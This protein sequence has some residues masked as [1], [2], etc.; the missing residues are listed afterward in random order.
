MLVKTFLIFTALLIQIILVIILVPQNTDLVRYWINVFSL[1]ESKKLFG[2]ISAS[3]I[4]FIIPS[5][6]WFSLLNQKK[7]LLIP[8]TFFLVFICII[9]KNFTVKF[10]I[11][12]E[13]QRNRY[14]FIKSDTTTYTT[15][16]LTNSD[17]GEGYLE[18]KIIKFK[19]DSI[20]DLEI[21]L[22]GKID[23]GTYKMNVWYPSFRELLPFSDTPF[24]TS[25]YSIHIDNGFMVE[26]NL[27]HENSL[28]IFRKYKF[29]NDTLFFDVRGRL[30]K[31][32]EKPIWSESNEYIYSNIWRLFLFWK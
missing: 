30:N 15:K 28:K 14:T 9:I 18:E 23:G 1:F 29:V 21:R 32:D 27:L 6:F 8:K 7:Y 4:Y 19:S 24:F 10:F 3:L 26:A 31:Y 17:T 16:Y 13:Y 25:K 11:H 5:L 22:F 2:I 12:D 20:A